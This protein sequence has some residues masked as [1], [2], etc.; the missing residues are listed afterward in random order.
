MS[1]IRGRRELHHRYREEGRLLQIEVE[2]ATPRLEGGRE[3]GRIRRERRMVAMDR[4]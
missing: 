3:S 2:G 4:T 1:R